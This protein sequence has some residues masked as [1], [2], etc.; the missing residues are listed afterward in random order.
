M[1]RSRGSTPPDWLSRRSAAGLSHQHVTLHFVRC[2]HR[3]SRIFSTA[4]LS[5]INEYRL[6]LD[7]LNGT[8]LM[9]L[10]CSG[11]CGRSGIGIVWTG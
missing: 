5:R 1:M 2:R 6:P 9:I 11:Y 3:D 8:G 4:L 10:L 7:Q